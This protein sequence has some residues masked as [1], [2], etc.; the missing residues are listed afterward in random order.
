VGLGITYNLPKGYVLNG[1]YNYASFE[2]DAASEI[3]TFQ[4]GFN[5][6]NNKFSLSFSNREIVK[7]IGFNI[8]YRWQQQYFWFNTWGAGNMPSYGLTDAAISYKL[9]SLKSIIKI[10]G[11]NIL[12]D[13]YRTNI[14]APFVGQMYYFSIT[15]DEFL[16]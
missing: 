2:F 3:A 6:P 8:S 1:S 11:T 10:G 16:N 15:F 5:T 12:G 14:G 13:D 9:K 4:P 7:N